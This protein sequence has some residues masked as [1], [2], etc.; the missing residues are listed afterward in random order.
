MRWKH[1]SGLLLPQVPTEMGWGV[2]EYLDNICYK[3]S[4]PK[5]AL[6]EPFTKLYTF[7]A[8]VFKEIAPGGKVARISL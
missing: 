7:Q 6:Q 1:G 8:H 4:A 3:A 2:S 5:D